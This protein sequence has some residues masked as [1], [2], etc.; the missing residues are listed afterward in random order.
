MSENAG[1]NDKDTNGHDQAV[2]GMFGRIARFYDLLNHVLSL[3][4]DC[5]WRW[6]LARSVRPGAHHRFLDLAA[7]TL[8]VSFALRRQHPDHD[9]LALD[10]CEPMLARGQRKMESRR[11][12]R[13]FPVAADGKHLPLPDNC[14][15]SVTI[16]FGIRNILPREE[17][18]K[19]M[20]RVLAPGGRVCILEFGSGRER[21]WLGIYN[22]Y[23]NRVLPAIG[24]LVS[25]D[26]GAYSY[27]SRT[28]H[29]FPSARELALEMEN[30]GFKRVHYTKLTSGIVCLHMGEKQG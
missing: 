18:L 11:E 30:V 13:V 4:I 2:S 22:F 10:F 29:D 7:G 9:V 28:I 15:D 20:H 24:R 14:V 1:T 26:K 27:L 5:Y 19:E 12:R 23:L 17:A 8:D 25:R 16:A 3:G 21:I 6:V